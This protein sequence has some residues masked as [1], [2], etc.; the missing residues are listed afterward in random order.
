MHPYAGR[1]RLIL[2]VRRAV[3]LTQVKTS[4]LGP[5]PER[6]AAAVPHLSWE[7]GRWAGLDDL[8]FTLRLTTLNLA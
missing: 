2:A 7:T 8:L 5:H 1:A 4:S 6:A 3:H